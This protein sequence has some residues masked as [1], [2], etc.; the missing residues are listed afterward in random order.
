MSAQSSNTYLR[1]K[2]VFYTSRPRRKSTSQCD[3]EK[4]QVSVSNEQD[5][6]ARI[7]GIA[8]FLRNKSNLRALKGAARLCIYSSIL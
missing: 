4:D 2:I 1:P 7:W 8:I 3:I 6:K 5:L